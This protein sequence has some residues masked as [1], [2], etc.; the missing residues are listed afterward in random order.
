MIRFVNS[1]K[2]PFKRFVCVCTKKGVDCVACQVI[3]R[4]RR[5]NAPHIGHLRYSVR[6]PFRELFELE[7][8]LKCTLHLQL[9]QICAISGGR[10]WT[11]CGLFDDIADLLSQLRGGGDVRIGELRERIEV[12]AN[13]AEHQKT[14][15]AVA[16]MVH[17][18]DLP[19]PD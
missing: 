16:E 13:R 4:Y 19:F 5:A 12:S 6:K 1:E 14:G 8:T 11:L 10:R 3:S 15:M 17:P 7:R 18:S 9:S 2:G